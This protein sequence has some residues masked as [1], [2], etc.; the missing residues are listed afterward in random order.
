VTRQ[1]WIAVFGLV[2]TGALP[3]PGPTSGVLPDGGPRIAAVAEA[4]AGAGQRPFEEVVKDLRSP[5]P[6]TRVT[7]MRALAAASY[8]ESMAPL[9]VL[10]TDPED[11][12]QLEAIDTLLSFVVTDTV[13]S[14]R[15]VALVVEVRDRQRAEGVFELGPFVLLPRP[16]VPE[17]VAGLAGAMRDANG[18]VR[19]DATYAMGV[20]VRAP[21]DE[22]ATGALIAALRDEDARVRRAAARVAGALRASGAGEALIAAVNDRQ[23]EVKAAAMRALGDVGETR[24]IQ[25][26]TEQFEFYQRG[27]LARAALD[28]LA[29]IAHPSSVPLFQAQL[30][31]REPLHR[32]FAAEGLARSGQ[33]SLS[34]PTLEAGIDDR[35][36]FASLAFAYAL[37]SVGR[38]SMERLVG[39][40]RDPRLQSQAMLYLTELGRPVARQLGTYLQDPEPV[41]RQSVAMVLGVV[42]GDEAIFALER[43]KQDPDTDVARAVERA[44]ARARMS[45]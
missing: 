29:R 20:L 30:T 9:A 10:L 27:E 24:A 2:A 4:A 21:A 45:R 7:A 23:A 22:V 26:L 44:I 43:A 1:G 40:L 13:A 6:A 25:A 33:A 12:I 16:V 35:D 34:L 36:R 38:P 42:G 15:R 5:D 19:L 41:V 3:S 18:R 28:G 8:P 11:E 37:Q 32:R 31:S 39:G 17:V 14:S